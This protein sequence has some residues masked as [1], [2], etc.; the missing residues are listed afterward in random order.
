MFWMLSGESPGSLRV[1]QRVD[2]H[3]VW[4]GSEE[5]RCD[6]PGFGGLEAVL[7]RDDIS[8]AGS[9]DPRDRVQRGAT[10]AARCGSES[11][12]HDGTTASFQ[13]DLRTM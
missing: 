13:I 1:G 7:G 5:C 3:I 10:L 8:S 2:A 11:C 12:L 9:V 6:L 4:V